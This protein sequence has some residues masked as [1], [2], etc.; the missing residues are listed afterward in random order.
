MAVW[1]RNHGD[2]C[3]CSNFIMSHLADTP[4]PAGFCCCLDFGMCVCL[5]SFGFIALL[6]FEGVGTNH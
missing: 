5:V 2:L 6:R 3:P 1:F 4:D